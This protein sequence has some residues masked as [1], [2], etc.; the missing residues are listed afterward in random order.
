MDWAKWITAGLLLMMIV[1]L[2]PR[3]KHMLQNSPKGS[4]QD[5]TGFAMVLGFVALFIVIL[6]MLVR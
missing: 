5:W 6:V 3:A 4:T 1:Y 2:F